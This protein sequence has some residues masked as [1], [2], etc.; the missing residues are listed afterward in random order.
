M[1][2]ALLMN[3]LGASVILATAVSADQNDAFEL[4]PFSTRGDDGPF[5]ATPVIAN[6]SFVTAEELE[7]INAVNVEDTIKYLPNLN[8]RKRYIGDTNGVTSIRGQ[9]TW[10]TGRSLVRVDGILISNFLQTRW[11]GSPRWA[12]VSPDEIQYAE[13]EYG[14]YSAF[15]S[16]NALGGAINLVT[17]MPS[18]KE[19]ALKTTYF[20]QDYSLYGSDDSYGGYKLFA[21]YGEQ[22]GNLSLYTFYNHLE[23]DSHPQT[24]R[25]A[26]NL[27]EPKADTPLANGAFHDQ[28]PR[29]RDRVVYNSTGPDTLE[30][31]QLKLKARYDFTE[32]LQAQ[33]SIVYWKNDSEQDQVENYLTD[34]NGDPI[35]GGVY[36]SQGQEFSVNSSHFRVSQRQRED[37]LAGLTLGGDLPNDWEFDATL[38][39]FNVIEDENRQSNLNPEDPNYTPSG[40]VTWFD[41]TDW[42]T[43]DLNLGSRSAFQNDSL[44]LF[45]GYHFSDYNLA[46]YQSNSNDWRVGSRDSVRNNTGG[47]TSAQALFAQAGYQLNESWRLTAGFRQE[48]WDA[49]GGYVEDA[50][51][52]GFHPDRSQS[53]SSP[54]LSLDYQPRDDWKLTLNIAK[55]HRF[56]LVPELFQ[57]QVGTDGRVDRNNPDLKPEDALATE[58][59]YIHYTEGGQIRLTLFRDEVEDAIFNLLDSELNYSL[60]LNIDNVET[61]GVEFVYD[62][63]SFLHDRLDLRFNA[64]YTDSSIEKNAANPAYEGNQFPRIPDWRLNLHANYRFDE[65]WSASLGARHQ[66]HSFNRLENDDFGNNYGSI[67]QFT[68]FDARLTYRLGEKKQSSLSLGIDNLLDEEYFV[69]HPYPQRTYFI[70]GSFRF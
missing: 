32:S 68:V 66:S 42:F 12:A 44:S 67:S 65:R 29:G 61:E 57:G 70:D 63:R 16:G 20:S 1:K 45:A 58:L 50:D 54:K 8:I 13:V 14:P 21:S 22:I 18:T 24:Y 52:I 4:A 41:D 47:Q 11:A 51:G 23:N 28:D 7:S 10:M 17:R 55:A 26:T 56:P 19:G 64:S 9:N 43:F 6:T 27:S 30:H 15:S 69:S 2:H 40:R 34:V 37:I 60:F 36:Q 35:W 46:L 53:E 38:S 48:W 62:Q 49:S 5:S 39:Y 3:V 59:S 33:L 31:D 25:S